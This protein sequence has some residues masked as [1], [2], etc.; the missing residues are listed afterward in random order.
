MKL[1]ILISLIGCLR[2]TYGMIRH[3]VIRVVLESISQT[4]TIQSNF[5]LFNVAESTQIS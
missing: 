5:D 4:M 1:H 2:S 3:G